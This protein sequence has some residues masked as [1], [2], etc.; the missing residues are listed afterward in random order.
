[1]TTNSP[2]PLSLVFNDQGR[3]S[4][5]GETINLEIS[6]IH[7]SSIITDSILIG[8][9]PPSMAGGA[10]NGTIVSATNLG[11]GL[12]LFNSSAV[13]GI[14]QFNSISSA[15]TSI[16]ISLGGNTVTFGVNPAVVAFVTALASY[17]TTAAAASTYLTQANAG[18]TYVPQAGLVNMTGPLSGT[19]TSAVF[20][21]ISA[22]NYIGVTG[23]GG[24]SQSTADSL[25]V[26]VSGDT[27]TGNLSMGGLSLSNALSVSSTSGT[28]TNLNFSKILGVA[29]AEG[30]I[31]RY[32]GANW[33]KL[34]LPGIPVAGTQYILT[35]QSGSTLSWLLSGTP[36]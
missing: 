2:R 30:D 36:I 8:G 12:G 5:L 32:D 3:V 17:L 29:P 1:M 28:F 35:C 15:D 11:T 18:T 4:R 34:S 31:I 23:A 22:T 9:A 21:T 24:I 26:N 20:N 6:S 14:L 33:S 16:S 7:V 10:G 13:G 19:T 27:M 25:Y